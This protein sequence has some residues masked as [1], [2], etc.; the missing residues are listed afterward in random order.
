M[1]LNHLTRGKACSR[2]G[3]LTDWKVGVGGISIGCCSSS[4]PQKC[5]ADQWGQHFF[6]QQ[7]PTPL[8]L[9]GRGRLCGTH[10]PPLYPGSLCLWEETD[11]RA[12]R[13]QTQDTGI[14]ETCREFYLSGVLILIFTCRVIGRKTCRIS[15]VEGLSTAHSTQEALSQQGLATLLR[16]QL[17]VQRIIKIL[18][19]FL[20]AVLLH[21]CQLKISCH[22]SVYTYA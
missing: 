12:D 10:P 20:V 7:V 2:S 17:L 9:S 13:R 19:P 5:K 16:C 21:C 8:L 14:A 6:F 11:K 3:I 1:S 15:R 4:P 18:M 22:L